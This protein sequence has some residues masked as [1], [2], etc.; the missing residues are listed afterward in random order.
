MEAKK[1]KIMFIIN[2]ISGVYKKKNVP[3][4][5]AR[6]IDYVQYDYTIR[7][8]Q[9]AGHATLIAQQ[10]VAEGYDVCVAVGGDGSIN[11]VAQSLVGT[12]TALGII[13]Y[14]SGN[15]FATHL[16]IPPRDAEGALR[17]LNTGKSVKLDLGKSNLRYFVSNAGFGIDS[18]VAR[19]FHHHAIRGLASYAWA[20]VKELLFYFQPFH[21]KVEIDDVTIERDFFLFTAFNANQY[22]YDYA[23]YPFTSMKDGVLDVIVLNRFP[24]WKLFW[25][26]GCLMMKRADL[27]KESES[28]RAKRIKIYGNKK[29]VYQFD[30]DSV[31]HHDDIEI[32]I[33]PSCIQVIVPNNLIAY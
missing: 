2:P 25:I 5:I 14:G 32:E 10:A 17:V 23:V 7:F 16:K 33:V 30:G 22:G 11:E 31:I 26:V 21:A 27:I 1:K 29:M 6:Y 13:P 15:G 28:Y 4:K 18:S 20:I 12:N 8:T 9:Y 3:E 24:L 19:R